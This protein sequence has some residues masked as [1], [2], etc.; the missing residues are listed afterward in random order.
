MARL[1]D[2]LR[3]KTVEQ[4]IA[5]TDEPG[6]R[7]RKD[8]TWRD[9]VVFGVSV[10]IGA[11]IFT[12]TAS[13]AGDITGPAIWISFL[14]AAGTCALA[15]LCYAEFA[16]TLPVAGSAYTFSY[17]TFGEFLAWVIGWNLVLELAIG[18]AV[19]AKGWSSYLGT[20]FGFSGGTAEFGSVRFDWGALVIV[21]LVAILLALGTKLSSRFSAVVTTIK[22]AV[23]LLVVVVGAFY[24]K[25]E[26]YR[27][28][29]PAPEAEHGGNGLDQSV[30]SML[31]GAGSSHYGWYGVLAGASIVF[32][33]FIGFDIVATMAE[34]T[35]HPQ[36]DVPR[37]ILA[38]LGV[39]TVLYVA[40]S[41]VLSGMVSYTQLKTVGRNSANLATAFRANGIHWAS[42]IIS[43]GALAGLTT[44]VMVLMLGQCRVL[45]AMARDGLLPRGLAK[46][47]AR[48]TPV[49]ITVLVAVVIAAT[50]SAFPIDKLEEMVNVGTLFAFVLVSAGV[51]VLRRTRPDLER[52]FKAPWVPLLPIASVC[53]CLW[54]M[55]NLTALTWVRFGVW[56]VLGA[57]IYFGYGRRHS[58]QGRRPVAQVE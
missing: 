50:A 37:G 1:K 17:A 49:R 25:A 19:V 56:L 45:F 51:I 54:L 55:L 16:S 8:L 29:I 12:V 33:A 39:V 10:V 6:T 36:R 38:S 44:V 7:L 26:N 42:G 46:T 14:I 21:A 30:L 32:F 23:V 31:T 41:V 11:G 58:V 27:P 13:T 18:A 53:A 57:A 28:F 47:G 2:S 43:V 3:T 22:V 9:L 34:E 24:V 52:G 5:D 35:K 4:S 48:G 20:V 40:V 15:A